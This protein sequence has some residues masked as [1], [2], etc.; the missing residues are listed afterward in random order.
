MS[1]IAIIE[2]QAGKFN[3][4]AKTIISNCY[5]ATIDVV[6]VD[7]ETGECSRANFT[8][9][10]MQNEAK[11]ATARKLPRTPFESI[12][13]DVKEYLEDCDFMGFSIRRLDLPLLAEEF[14]RSGIDNFPHESVSIIDIQSIYHQMEPRN[15]AAAVKFYLN[16]EYLA[17]QRNTGDVELV[18][19]IFER[20]REMYGLTDLEQLHEI[21]A[22]GKDIADFANLTYWQDNGRKLYWNFGKNKDQPVTAEDPFTIWFLRNDFPAQ[23]QRIVA[24]YTNIQIF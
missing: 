4:H 16:R 24:D 11:V 5:I 9:N 6:R 22:F 15:F 7:Y 17:P 13:W 8:V 14:A 21:S 12:A 3:P 2:I 20:Q 18:R 10:P 23:S 1:K 19:Q